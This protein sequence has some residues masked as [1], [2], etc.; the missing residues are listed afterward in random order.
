MSELEVAKQCFIENIKLFGDPKQSP[1]KFN[2][3]NG[4]LQ[5]TSAISRIEH[6]IQQLKAL[7]AKSR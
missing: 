3:Y 4:L 6:D 1:E 7:Y 2:F 5:L